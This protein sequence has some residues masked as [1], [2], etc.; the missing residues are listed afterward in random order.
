MEKQQLNI[1]IGIP[2]TPIFL[3]IRDVRYIEK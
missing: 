2:F 1:M 3:L